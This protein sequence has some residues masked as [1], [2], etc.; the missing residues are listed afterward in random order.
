MGLV[1]VYRD[2]RANAIF[3]EDANGVQF[4]NSLQALQN[5]SNVDIKDLAKN[6]DLVSN[7]NYIDFVDENDNSYGNN[8]SEVTNALNH[9]FTATG[10]PTGDLP[11]ITSPTS[12]NAVANEI[13]NYEMT[14]DYG[15]GYE[16]DSLPN[17]LL[18]VEGNVRKLI[19]SLPT[20]TYTPTMKAVNYNGSDE[21]TLTI[22]VSNPPFANTKSINFV[23]FDYLSGNASDLI[24]LFGRASNGSG[25]SDAWSI[26][27]YFKAGTSNNNNQ[28]IFNYGAD[29]FGGRIQLRY[30]GSQDRIELF[31][32]SSF[33]SLT[34]RSQNN[35]LP[36][37]VWKHILVTYDGGTTGSA[38]GSVNDY[39]S[40]F[41]IFVNGIEVTYNNT[42]DNFGYSADIPDDVI[43]VG[44]YEFGDYMRN[45]CRIDELAFWDSDQQANIS[46]IYNSGNPFDLKAL[47]TQPNNWYR[48]GD[49]D[50][51]PT[52]QDGIGSSN[53]TMVNMTS[54]DIVN[55]VP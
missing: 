16:W 54:A 5:N 42:N 33:N 8:S 2:D 37:G 26:S 25:A 13:I 22:N 43:Q 11:V 21:E 51:Y 4:L 29:F 32:G 23:N 55:D 31:Y 15:V 40:R 50:T 49:G 24:N 53:L 36:T 44:R 35:L 41:K 18:T 19:G 30:N 27:L 47:G 48:M 20:G 52:L 28:T 39:Y 7:T 17:G 46:N 45:N 12:I 10:T 9:I 3:L 34:I 1:K 14:A 38:S 6:I